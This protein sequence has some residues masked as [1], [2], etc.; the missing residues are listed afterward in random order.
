VL[1]LLR[2]LLPAGRVGHTL[3]HIHCIIIALCL[4]KAARDALIIVPHDI[5]SEIPPWLILYIHTVVMGLIFGVVR[6]FFN[7][8]TNHVRDRI[9]YALQPFKV[10]WTLCARLGWSGGLM[11]MMVRAGEQREQT[12][13]QTLGTNADA[14]GPFWVRAS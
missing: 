1:L 11:M 5:M 9:L 4:I 13:I 10:R 3:M 14:Y 2:P 6:Q 8:E 7:V 12:F